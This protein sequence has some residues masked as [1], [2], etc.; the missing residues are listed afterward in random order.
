[1]PVV[2]DDFLGPRSL[3]SPEELKAAEAAEREFEQ[4]R[5]DSELARRLQEQLAGVEGGEG[6]D[7]RLAREA[8]VT[9]AFSRFLSSPPFFCRTES[10]QKCY[11]RERKPRREEQRRR[12]GQESWNVSG[13]ERR[14]SRWR[15]SRTIRWRSR[16]ER[17]RLWVVNGHIGR[18]SHRI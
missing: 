7:Q 13:R 3:L 5:R 8:Q 2:P 14:R 11:K 12:H 15:R 10:L 1:M 9:W 4:E 18:L 17:Q 16:K 6:E